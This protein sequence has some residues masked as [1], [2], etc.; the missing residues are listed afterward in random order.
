MRYRADIDGLRAI[1]IVLVVAYHVGVPGFGGGFIGVDVFFVI[2]GYLITGLLWK[3]LRGTGRISWSRFYARRA[4]RLLPALTVVVLGTLVMGVFLMV[5]DPELRWLSQSV[6]AVAAFVSNVFFWVKTSGYFGAD[7]EALPLLN[8]WSLSVEEQFYII[9][10]LLLSGAAWMVRRRPAWGQRAV[11][12]G[13][14]LIGLASF[15]FSVALVRVD[16]AAAFFWMPSRLW[17][18]AAGGL[19]ALAATRLPR[20]ST[21]Q[22]AALAAVGLAM[23]GFSTLT[24]ETGSTFPGLAAVPVVF[25]T[26]LVVAAGSRAANPVSSTL[27]VAPLVGIGKLSYSWYLIHWPLLTFARMATLESDLTRDALIA[28]GSLGLAALSYRYVEQ[29]ARAQDWAIVKGSR[30]SLVAGAL[31][32]V[33]L[34]MVGALVL[35]DSAGFARLQMSVSEAQALEEDRTSRDRCP[36]KSNS[37][38]VDCAFDAGRNR[39]L[40]LMGDS[41]ALAAL[42]IAQEIAAELDWTLEVLWD[43]G[44]PFIVGYASPDGMRSIS[45]DCERQNEINAEYIADNATRIG[46]IL[47]TA[48]TSSYLQS[49]DETET[50]AATGAW[51]RSLGE[52]IEGATRLDIPVIVMNDVPRFD[53]PVPQCTIRLGE[54]CDI[55]R[56]E[57]SEYRQAA[58]GAELAATE[59][60]PQARAWDPFEVLCGDGVCFVQDGDEV[61]YRDRDHLSDAGASFVA[62][63][64]VPVAVSWFTDSR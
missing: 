28:L 3:E 35:R 27:A 23:V 21:L 10:P 14:G 52:T 7:A 24:L 58:Y 15:A 63:D 8:M 55:D 44:C 33:A 18:L 61:L 50:A 43:T 20:W 47:T 6:I 30:R 12:L 22:G 31:T 36:P 11:P 53:H 57:A 40:L 19:L 64:L 48:R 5:P 42:P 60:S 49:D 4:R 16:Q 59:V 29:P 62:A 45:G 56:E 46:G 32:L 51:S 26:V 1:A 2:S 25:G 34:A 38:A 17:E 41:H 54:G 37:E 39:S 13:I 9:W